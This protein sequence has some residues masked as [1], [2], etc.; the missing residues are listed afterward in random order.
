MT[1]LKLS[2]DKT[3]FTNS[4]LRRLQNPT[5]KPL[6]ACCQA[7]I[8]IFIDHY[9]DKIEEIIRLCEK[10]LKEAEKF[11]TVIVTPKEFGTNTERNRS[12]TLATLRNWLDLLKTHPFMVYEDVGKSCKREYV[13]LPILTEH[14]IDK[15]G[16]IKLVFNPRLRFHISKSYTFKE[17][18]APC[19]LSLVKKIKERDIY[20]GILFEEA[21]S[22]ANY[23]V[24][25]NE[26]FFNWS[27]QELRLKF[28][29]DA[30]TDLSEDGKEFQTKKIKNMRIDNLIHKYLTPALKVLEDFFTAGKT[31]FWLEMST[32][33]SGRKKAGRP[34]KDSFH[35]V[36]RKN[37][38]ITIRQGYK[39]AL[40]M[41]MFDTYEEINNYT[42]LKKEFGFVFNS[43]KYIDVII[44]Q[45]E[46]KETEDQ[47]ISDKVLQK[48][49][50]IRTKY[51]E[52]KR[53][54]EWRKILISVLAK[55]FSLCIKKKESNTSQLNGEEWPSD[56][57]LKIDEMKKSFEI[58]DRAARE[59]NLSQEEVLSILDTNFRVFCHKTRKPLKDWEDATNLFFNVIDKKWLKDYENN[60]D[61]ATHGGDKSNIVEEEAI[62]YFKEQRLHT[63]F[64]F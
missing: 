5:E 4:F 44:S 9:G 47:T 12:R 15:E 8:H 16:N 6:D 59:H 40:Q 28:L 56:L 53:K 26:P 33:F 42:E 34:P 46:N 23:S 61:N 31:N 17:N 55:D 30:I 3:I 52:T 43:N 57:D 63:D 39:K 1:G 18:Y 10:N 20:A 38:R 49:R 37:P 62:R 29:F 25:K 41:E 54:D 36:I 45:I 2:N 14:R 27:L 48:V 7:L 19:S 35:F 58:C 51:G 24:D 22:W 21:S 60:R 32:Y 50:N 13:S 64:S 11:L